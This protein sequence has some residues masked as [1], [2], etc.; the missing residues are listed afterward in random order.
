MSTPNRGDETLPAFLAERLEPFCDRFESEW[1]AGHRPA[2]GAYLALVE[3]GDRP[4]LLRELLALE[5]EY[6]ARAGE[7]PTPEEY[8]PRLPGHEQL[9]EA[10]FALS[11]E[12]SRTEA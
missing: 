11:L 12:K 2:L 7:R 3:E 9:I 4:A 1:V 6:R 5:L 8:H 10:A